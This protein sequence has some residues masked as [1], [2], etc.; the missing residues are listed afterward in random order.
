MAKIAFIQNFV[1]EYLGVMSMAAVL[2]ASGH[3]VEVFIG[4]NIGKITNEVKK[5]GFDIVGFSCTTGNHYWCLKMAASIK[6]NTKALTVFGGPHPTFFPEI[7]IEHQVDIVCRGEGEGAILEMANRMDLKKSISDVPGLCFKQ[8]SGLTLKCNEVRSLINDLDALPSPDRSLY[9]KKY[10][11]LNRSQKMFMAGRGC[12]FK[13]SYC[14]NEALQKLYMNK[15]VYVRYRSVGNVIDEINCTRREYGLQ[16]VYMMDD[17]FILNKKWLFDFLPKYKKE[18]N[19]PFICLIRA[20]LATEEIIEAL[21]SANCYAAFF[22]VESGDENIRNFILDKNISDEQLIETARLLKK[23][24][25][26]FRTYNMVGLPQEDINKAFST[27]DLNIRM[28]T[29]YPWCSILQPYPRT[30]ISEFAK[31]KGILKDSPIREYFFKDSVLDLPD[32]EQLANLQKLFFW[33]VKFPF[34]KPLVKKLIKLPPNFMFN[35][36]FLTGYA[37]S[38]YKSERLKI[39]EMFIIGAKNISTFLS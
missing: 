11:F 25:I 23:Y 10:P 8:E 13:C 20:D 14:F 21:K 37:Y 7:V 15:G 6:D 17:T 18:L 26:R 16:T 22:G 24:K 35:I 34:I 39:G 27:V 31:D 12:P 36:L 1:Y 32:K 9:Y 2:K 5:C 29:D 19:L 28:K 4:K 38:Y 3:E 30:P 33:V